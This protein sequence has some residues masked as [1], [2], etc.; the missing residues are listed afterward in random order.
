MQRM[1]PIRIRLQELIAASGDSYSGLSLLLGRNPAYI[2]QFMTRG[3]PRKLSES[4]SRILASYFKVSEEELG[5]TEMPR[6]NQKIPGGLATVPILNLAVSA[7]SGTKP[8]P[9][10]SSASMSFDPGWLGRL[11]VESDRISIVQI[12]GDSM[13]PTLCDGDE[14]MVDHDDDGSRLRDGIYLV[15]LDDVLMVKRIVPGPRRGQITVG[16]DNR[17]YPTWN[18]LDSNSL[19]IIGRVVWYGR[20]LPSRD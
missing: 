5:G 11:G 16:S 15:R 9:E 10:L 3:T 8:S 17:S 13:A 12:R 18:G 4:D 6:V 2:H 7:G 20:R 1:D 14:V 19:N